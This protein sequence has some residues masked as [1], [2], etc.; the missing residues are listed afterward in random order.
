MATRS[1][2]AWTQ[3]PGR[4]EVLTPLSKVCRAA[5][6]AGVLGFPACLSTE[7]S[8]VQPSIGLYLKDQTPTYAFVPGTSIDV[9]VAWTAWCTTHGIGDGSTT[10]PCDEQDFTARVTCSGAPCTLDPPAASSGVELTGD[11]SITI[12]TPSPGDLTIES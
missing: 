4:D 1:T 3:S 8:E 12:G 11:S 5:A 9:Y 2:S 6:L 7:R 10:E